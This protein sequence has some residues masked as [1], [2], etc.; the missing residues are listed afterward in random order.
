MNRCVAFV[1]A[2]WRWVAVFTM[3][4]IANDVYTLALASDVATAFE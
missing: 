4:P 2:R 1:S 3:I